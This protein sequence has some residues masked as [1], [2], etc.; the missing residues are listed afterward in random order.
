MNC[1]VPVFATAEVLVVYAKKVATWVV[2]AYFQV[3]LLILQ[4]HC[5]YVSAPPR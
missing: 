3:K 2:G 1:F 4:N 5:G